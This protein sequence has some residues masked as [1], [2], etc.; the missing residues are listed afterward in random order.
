MGTRTFSGKMDQPTKQTSPSWFTHC[1]LLT[2]ERIRIRRRWCFI[3]SL[4]PG[5]WLFLQEVWRRHFS[6]EPPETDTAADIQGW[7]KGSSHSGLVST[8]WLP[9]LCQ[10]WA[11]TSLRPLRLMGRWEGTEEPGAGRA[12]LLRARVSVTKSYSGHFSVLF[13]FGGTQQLLLS[14]SSE[15][16]P[17]GLTWPYE[18][19][20]I[21][22][23]LTGCKASALP[24]LYYSS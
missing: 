15:I 4:W 3:F 17:S 5:M 8:Q 18:M 10:Y 21:E 2:N 20:R 22:T 13:L 1:L 7:V 23:R 12:S 14:L 6:A 19:L 9:A 16:T 11:Y 24:F